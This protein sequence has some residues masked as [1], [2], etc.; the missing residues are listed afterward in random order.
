MDRNAS[1]KPTLPLFHIN[2]VLLC[3]KATTTKRLTSRNS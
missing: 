2:L 1:S 3:L